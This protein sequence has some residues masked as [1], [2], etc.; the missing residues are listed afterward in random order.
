MQDVWDEF[1]P[2]AFDPDPLVQHEAH[3]AFHHGVWA[4]SENR[5][6]LRLWPVTEALITIVVAQDQAARADPARAHALHRDQFE[7]I[8]S[9]DLVQI[10]QQL[11]RH[12]VDSAEEFLA[13]PSEPTDAGS[14]RQH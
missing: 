3:V 1:E 13:L 12:T 10:E 7:A 5:M 11:R 9:G 8:A 6:L 14:L 2:L 4:A